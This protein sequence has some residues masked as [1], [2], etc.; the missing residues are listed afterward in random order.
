M[1]AAACFLALELTMAT[2]RGTTKALFLT[3][4]S[5]IPSGPTAVAS[6]IPSRDAAVTLAWK[7]F[8]RRR[9]RR[10]KL[11]GETFG[12]TLLVG[13]LLVGTPRWGVR[14]TVILHRRSAQR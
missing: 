12:T 10:R 2:S 4:A 6:S 14:E 3:A 9:S 13:T 11:C 1:P 7:K 5:P 8:S